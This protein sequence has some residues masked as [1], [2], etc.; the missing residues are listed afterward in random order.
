VTGEPQDVISVGLDGSAAS[1]SAARWAAAVSRQRGARLRL[2][3]AWEPP[4]TGGRPGEPDES[5]RATEAR[6]VLEEAREEVRRVAPDLPV[7]DSLIEDDPG[8][9]L[10]AVAKESQ[11]LALGTHGMRRLQS[12]FLGGTSLHV[13]ARAERPVILVR[14]GGDGVE[15]AEAAEAEEAAEAAGA[16]TAPTVQETTHRGAHEW[17]RPPGPVVVGLPLDH[18]ADRLLE[19][20]F[21]A[22]DGSDLPLRVIHGAKL[23]RHAYL[24]GGPVIPH[25]AD[26]FRRN[27]EQEMRSL[28]NPWSDRFPDVQTKGSLRLDNPAGALVQE[29]AGAALLVVGRSRRRRVGARVGSVAQAAVHHAAC[30]VAI[31]PHD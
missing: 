2:V 28:V 1:L 14:A 22:A 21:T 23:P 10:L 7:E 3:H 27:I 12:F 25:L 4:P 19:F 9:A 20:A 24:P 31:V 17:T 18:T 15:A 6:R 11:A 5:P 8:A 16:D 13:V 29:A 26:E 30:P